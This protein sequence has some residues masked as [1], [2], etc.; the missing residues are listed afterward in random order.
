MMTLSP[1]ILF[2]HIKKTVGIRA[3]LAN[4][5]ANSTTQISRYNS[6]PFSNYAGYS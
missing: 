3:T 2:L 1:Y 6:D 4:N 5:L